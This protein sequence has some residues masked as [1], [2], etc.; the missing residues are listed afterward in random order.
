MRAGTLGVGVVGAATAVDGVA[1]APATASGAE[2]GA[3][4]GD[5]AS[6]AQAARVRATSDVAAASGRIAAHDSA[7]TPRRGGR[8]RRRGSR[9]GRA[10]GRRGR[11]TRGAAVPGARRTWG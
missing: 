6:G 3:P 1:G 4:A 8:R 10:R 5:F 7:I 9:A 2:G 11:R